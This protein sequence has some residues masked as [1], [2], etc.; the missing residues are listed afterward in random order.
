MI[1]VELRMKNFMCYVEPSPLSFEGIHL[2]CLTGANGH[3][4][5]AILDAITWALWGKARDGKRS[6]DELIHLGERDME[7]SLMFR[8]DQVLYRVTR[9]RQNGIIG[10]GR[11]TL[12]LD[13]GQDYQNPLSG[14][15]IRKT[16]EQIDQLLRMSYNV[17]INSAFLLQGRADEFTKRSAGDRKQVLVEMLDFAQYD[18][19]EA[20]ANREAREASAEAVKLCAQVEAAD[21]SLEGADE[22]LDEKTLAAS[23]LLTVTN[24]LQVANDAQGVLRKESEALAAKQVRAELLEDGIRGA[25][26]ELSA[27]QP[28]IRGIGARLEA[29]DV[30]TRNREEIERA[31]AQLIKAQARREELDGLR[32]AVE[33]LERKKREQERLVEEAKRKLQTMIEIQEAS[34]FTLKVALT[35]GQ[36][37]ADKAA[38]VGIQLDALLETEQELEDGRAEVAAIALR[39]KELEGEGVRKREEEESLRAQHALLSDTE[40]DGALC[41]TCSQEL[42]EEKRWAL[43]TDTEKAIRD[44]ETWIQSAHILYKAM[45]DSI[46]ALWETNNAL[47]RKLAGRDELQRTLAVAQQRLR[48]LDVAAQELEEK[49]AGLS[50]LQCRMDGKDYAHDGRVELGR[51]Q[52]LI[53]AVGYDAGEHAQLQA[54]MVVARQQEAQHRQLIE[55]LASSGAL[56]ERKTELLEEEGRLITG[57]MEDR[58]SCEELAYLEEL[59]VLTQR[60]ADHSYVMLDKTSAERMARGRMSEL[61]A[62]VNRNDEV[63]MGREALLG[64]L[65]VARAEQAIYED[66]REAFGRRG[67]QAMVIDAVIPEIEADANDLLGR[68]T[69]GRMRVRFETLREKKSDRGKLVETLDILISDEKGTR[70]YSLYSGGEA[71]RINFAIR[72]ALSKLL[73]RRSGASLQILVVDEGFGTQDTEGLVR[74]VEAIGAVKDDFA[75]VLVITHIESLKDA[76]PARIDVVKTSQG[77][78][79]TVR[80]GN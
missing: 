62:L 58:A 59:V 66:L 34:I 42:D 68:M 26:L 2:A 60:M 70:D 55:A 3:G 57:I 1:L 77:S 24:E 49:Q 7:V 80:K 28:K 53:S 33:K 65:G 76:F 46:D 14:N 18:R 27:I 17:F 15:T 5:S 20:L 51:L 29:M 22:L 8:V 43:L 31:F 30:I 78:Q 32:A 54:Q 36:S 19:Y 47:S 67:V 61:A 10:R 4:K 13:T 11:S 45:G 35:T 50:A 16:Q 37:I 73:A 23:Y 71:F 39:R 63:A 38:I 25:E 74:L 56:E 41:P 64:I 12:Q 72:V 69:N 6:A 75:Q 48:E 40:S 44:V 52:V 79:I 21:K 9:S